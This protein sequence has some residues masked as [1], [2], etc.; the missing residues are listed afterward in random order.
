MA[1]GRPG[2][3]QDSRIDGVPCVGRI[4]AC[5]TP[6]ILGDVDSAVWSVGKELAAAGSSS[7]RRSGSKGSLGAAS[8]SPRHVRSSGEAPRLRDGKVL[9]HRLHQGY[10]SVAQ[11]GPRGPP[12]QGV[13]EADEVPLRGPQQSRQRTAG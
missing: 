1:H 11:L 12:R 7:L 13:Q 5:Q 2:L 6:D 3:G 10:P 9:I 4:G 8:C